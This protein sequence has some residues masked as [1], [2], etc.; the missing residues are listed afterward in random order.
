MNIE[1]YTRSNCS[2]CDAVKDALKDKQI[3]YTEHIIGETILREKVLDQFPGVT[4]LPIVTIDGTWIGGRDEIL[5]K[6][7]N[8]DIS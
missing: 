4:L 7:A 3:S 5:L 1:L 6:L 2:R 8:N